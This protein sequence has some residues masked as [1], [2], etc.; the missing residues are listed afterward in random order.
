MDFV[1]NDVHMTARRAWLIVAPA[2]EEEGERRVG[3]ET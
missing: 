3:S 2:L 1:E